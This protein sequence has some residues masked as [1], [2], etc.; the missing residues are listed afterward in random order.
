MSEAED[1]K[2]CD[3]CGQPA[4][5]VVGDETLCDSCYHTAGSCCGME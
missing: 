1:E 3:R 4:S 5:A 2:P